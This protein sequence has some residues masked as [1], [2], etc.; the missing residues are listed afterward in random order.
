MI[1][2]TNKTDQHV[3]THQPIDINRLQSSTHN[4]LMLSL[5]FQMLTQ[6]S[7]D[8]L[9]LTIVSFSTGGRLVKNIGEANSNFGGQNVVKTD[10]C[11]GVSNIMWAA[12]PTSIPISFRLSNE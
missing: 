11:M 12:P 5:I 10:K 7:V 3:P 4:Y 8:V 9:A 1:S 6:N 2:S